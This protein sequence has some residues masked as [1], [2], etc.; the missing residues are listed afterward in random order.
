[1][2]CTDVAQ[3]SIG[4]TRF[5]PS[6]S[7]CTVDLGRGERASDRHRVRV[8]DHQPALQNALPISHDRCL[9]R[10]ERLR[11]MPRGVVIDS[12]RAFT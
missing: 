1:M 7:R 10:V 4:A 2:C 12:P 9:I 3:G 8:R 6:A 11:G 5:Q